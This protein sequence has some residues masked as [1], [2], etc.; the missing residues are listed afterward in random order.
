M[1]L[2]ACVP[3]DLG[4]YL[5]K[6]RDFDLVAAKRNLPFAMLLHLGHTFHQ[7]SKNVSLSHYLVLRNRF[8]RR[9][10]RSFNSF[11]METPVIVISQIIWQTTSESRRFNERYIRR[12]TLLAYLVKTIR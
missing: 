4:I 8:F 10:A 2:F 3:N 9:P 12:H 6:W 1:K 5:G 11:S 7:F